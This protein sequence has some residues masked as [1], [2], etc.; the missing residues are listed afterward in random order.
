MTNGHCSLQQEVGGAVSSPVVPGQGLG[1]VLGEMSQQAQSVV[2]MALPYLLFVWE[3]PKLQKFTFMH[4][5][6][7]KPYTVW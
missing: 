1:G 3:W 2:G 7:L 4:S 6:K 5:T